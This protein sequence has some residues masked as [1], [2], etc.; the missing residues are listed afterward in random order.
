LATLKAGA[1]YTLLDPDFPTTRLTTITG[2]SHATHL[3]TT[4]SHNTEWSSDAIRVVLLDRDATTIATQP[5]TPP[6][7][8]ITPDDTACVMFT[9]GSTGTPKGVATPHQ[10]LT[11]TLTHQHF[12]TTAPGDTWLQCSPIPWD[13]YAL[14]LFTPLL[15]GA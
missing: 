1:A 3:I 10:A 6:G 4:T 7:I 5:A 14:E 11:T 2:H 13:A 9:S 12:T 15:H 8:P